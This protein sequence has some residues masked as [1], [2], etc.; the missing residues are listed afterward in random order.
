MILWDPKNITNDWGQEFAIAS[1][2]DPNGKTAK[3]RAKVDANG[4]LGRFEVLDGGSLYN[5]SEGPILVSLLPPKPTSNLIETDTGEVV[6][7]P[8]GG[9]INEVFVQEGDKVQQGDAL[10]NVDV[11]ANDAVANAEGVIGGEGGI[12]APVDDGGEISN[13]TGGQRSNTVPVLTEI[14]RKEGDVFYQGD[15][16][17]Q[18]LTN[19]QKGDDV[20]DTRKFMKIST[21]PNGQVQEIKKR[22]SDIETFQQGDQI[23]YEGKFLQATEEVAPN[24]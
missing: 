11:T 8:K 9:T 19:S 21:W 10:V 16:Y 2:S 20:S 12:N 13:V 1:P 15:S 4:N 7:A 17:Y 23:Y 3:V 24:F 18:A 22:H 14:A 5:D 6:S